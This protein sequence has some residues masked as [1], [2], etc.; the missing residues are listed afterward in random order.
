MDINSVA[1]RGVLLAGMAGEL[2]FESGWFESFSDLVMQFLRTQNESNA[3]AITSDLQLFKLLSSNRE[4]VTPEKFKTLSLKYAP[5]LESTWIDSETPDK[6]ETLGAWWLLE[7]VL[8]VFLS[9]QPDLQFEKL[10]EFLADEKVAVAVYL[11]QKDS[12]SVLSH[13]EKWIGGD[14]ESSAEFETRKILLW[15]AFFE[16]F[17]RVT[18]AGFDERFPEP[19]MMKMFLPVAENNKLI[20]SNERYV[21]AIKQKC[22]GTEES[23]GSFYEKITEAKCTFYSKEGDD[24]KAAVE[25]SVKRIRAGKTR[26]NRKNYESN[27]RVLDTE[28]RQAP[29]QPVELVAIFCEVMTKKQVAMLN[30]NGTPTDIEKVFAVYPRIYEQFTD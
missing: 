13:I 20:L 12:L 4:S 24:P 19:A 17:L 21:A 29:M 3:A 14:W 8:N 6:K 10:N 27:F 25:K 15:L 7:I 23:W 26:L 16:K 18:T 9:R 28:L 30:D 5:E 22:V 2:L 1:N 11:Q